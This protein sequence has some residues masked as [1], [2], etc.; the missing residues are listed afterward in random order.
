MRTSLSEYINHN[1]KGCQVAFEADNGKDLIE[2]LEKSSRSPDLCILDIFMP[3]LNGLETL[4]QLRLRWPDIKV[5]ILTGQKT[6]YYV[7]QMIQAGANGYLK[8]NCSPSEL[9]IAIRS[10]HQNGVFSSD[11]M[12][13]VLY[14]AI[15]NRGARLSEF[16]RME[17]ELL[18]HCCSDLN[19]D[20]IA[21]KLG[22]T[23]RS[24]DWY[25]NSLFKKLSVRSRSSLV[26]YAIQFGLVDLDI[27]IT[28]KS[29]QV[30]RNCDS[31]N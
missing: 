22:T 11:S 15:K 19:Y 14:K 3:V 24:V 17:I 29:V 20:Q 16:S 10:I 21:E 25:R 26:M 18:R 8:K 5:L 27:D 23:L 9:E 2:Q 30:K 1:F 13:Q 28:G 4:I 7:I 6:E 31:L 12:T